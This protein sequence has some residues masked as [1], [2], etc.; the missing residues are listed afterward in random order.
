MTSIK[1]KIRSD[2]LEL[3]LDLFKVAT[4]APGQS[5]GIGPGIEVVHE[6]HV[7]RQGLIES[8]IIID[9][10]LKVASGVTAKLVSDWIVGALKGRKATVRIGDKEVDA[11]DKASVTSALDDA[12]K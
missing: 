10:L 4:P 12:L 8:G 5:F 7:V 6:H 1:I 2:S 11:H 9:L 3:P